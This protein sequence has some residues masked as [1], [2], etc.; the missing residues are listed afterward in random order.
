MNLKLVL[1]GKQ[2]ELYWNRARIR[3]CTSAFSDDSHFSKRKKLLS[4]EI[5]VYEW[6]FHFLKPSKY[7]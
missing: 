4:A 1:I 2:T 5:P 6:E 7:S 3:L